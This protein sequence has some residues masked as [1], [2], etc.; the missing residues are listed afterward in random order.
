MGRDPRIEAPGAIYHVGSKGNRGCRVYADDHEFEVFL[1]LLGR[2]TARYDWICHS[3]CL[4][5]NHYHLIVQLRDGGL[6]DGMRE[7]NGGFSRFTN[8]RHG[9]EGHLFRNRFWSD[10]ILDEARMYATARYVA[11]N[12]VRAD[13]CPTAEGWRWSSYRACVGLD[14]APPF[15][16]VTEHL[17]HFGRT[18]AE[19]RRTFRE[20]VAQGIDERRP[21]GRPW[22]QTQ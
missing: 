13:L 16:A 14:F 6:S 9:L 20:F 18:P 19:A 5:T 10:P 8:A 2:I 3:Y 15:L 12:P 11:L 17:E 21:R 1:R 4:M 7:L 22:C